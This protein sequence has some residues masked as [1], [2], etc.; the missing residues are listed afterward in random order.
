MKRWLFFSQ[1]RK[2]FPNA[3]TVL[4]HIKNIVNFKK[5]ELV[6]DGA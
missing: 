6:W 5:K 1:E 4:G 2:F 3:G